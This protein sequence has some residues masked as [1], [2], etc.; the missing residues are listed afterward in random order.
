M[1]SA[2]EIAMEKLE[3]SS[4]PSRSLSEEQKAEIAEIDSKYNAQIAEQ[5]LGFDGKIAQAASLE[6]LQQLKA[7]HAATLQAI[8]ERRENAKN[9]VWDKA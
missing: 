1:K 6:A 5:Q 2:Y 9:A 8:E 3:K 7:E 4:G